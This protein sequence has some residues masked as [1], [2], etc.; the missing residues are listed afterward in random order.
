MKELEIVK[1]EEFSNTENERFKI[2]FS[3]TTQQITD[4]TL[5]TLAHL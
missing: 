2:E 4:S 3:R 5:Q 1:F